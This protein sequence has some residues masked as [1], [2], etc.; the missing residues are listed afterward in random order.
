MRIQLLEQLT[1]QTGVVFPQG[2]EWECDSLL[3]LANGNTILA[4]VEQVAEGLL[5][6]REIMFV[7]PK[8]VPKL[9]VILDGPIEPPKR[10][11]WEGA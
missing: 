4:Q 7:A 9:S 8:D 6:N 3:N 5:I 10:K 1:T 11:D 2:Y